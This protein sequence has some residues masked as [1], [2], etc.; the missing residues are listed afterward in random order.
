MTSKKEPREGIFH[1]NISNVGTDFFTGVP[2]QIEKTNPAEIALDLVDI[3]ARYMLGEFDDSEMQQD[4]Q[5]RDFFMSVGMALLA[6]AHPANDTLYI[7]VK[8]LISQWDRAINDW[9][10]DDAKHDAKVAELDEKTENMLDEHVDMVAEIACLWKRMLYLHNKL[11]IK[12]KSEIS[13]EI[14][15][16]ILE[17]SKVVSEIDLKAKE[18][19]ANKDV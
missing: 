10:N 16:E 9:E 19:E 17:L 3:C 6:M 4:K 14:N 2:V 5:K 7:T 1:A 11:K 18:N 12:L 15:D 8:H 13:M